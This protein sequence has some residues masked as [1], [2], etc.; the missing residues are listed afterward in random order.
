MGR[1]V[2]EYDEGAVTVGSDLGDHAEKG[3][4]ECGV[5]DCEM[6]LAVVDGEGGEP[7]Q[8]LGSRVRVWV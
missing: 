3:L 2:G 1:E 4:D 6:G 8:D 7:F 5:D